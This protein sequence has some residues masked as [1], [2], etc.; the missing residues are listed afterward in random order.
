MS[1]LLAQ[2]DVEGRGP[3][4]VWLWWAA[5]AVV[6]A[7]LVGAAF[8]PVLAVHY[9]WW[10]LW[11]NP[12]PR[13]QLLVAPRTQI[14]P[15]IAVV[16]T[17]GFLTCLVSYELGRNYGPQG[18]SMLSGRSPR[19]GGVLS[20]VSE[21][22]AQHS[23]LFLLFVPGW[24]TS[25]FAGTNGLSRARAMLPTSFGLVLWASINYRV[26]HW[27]A[28]W[29]S[30]VLALVRQYMLTASILCIVSVAL[31]QWLPRREQKR[32]VTLPV[33]PESEVEVDLDV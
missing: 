2:T 18:V 17:R 32:A 8:A 11:L 13:H 15:F 7:T 12:W 29:I 20:V 26:G 9:P 33:D 22:F 5:S 28:P 3:A 25:A 10:L 21:Q 24:M 27:L 23:R 16:A 19:V 1:N 14:L 31:Y 4:P 6:I 30:A